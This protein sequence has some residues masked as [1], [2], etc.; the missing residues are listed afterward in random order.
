MKKFNVAL[1]QLAPTSSI[2]QNLAKGLD[3]CKKA[4]SLGADLALFPEMWQLNYNSDLM[5]LD[6]TIDHS[7]NFVQS[8]C[9]QA[10]QLNMA[11]AITY[12]GKGKNK[13]TNNV[14]VIDR[15]GTVVLDYAKVHVCDFAG[16]SEVALESGSEF[17]IAALNFAGGNVKL[18]AMIC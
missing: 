13:P 11:I 7:D 17:K 8:F 3:A 15:S 5:T 9:K 2:E 1:L 18:G 16:G 14:A 6:N 10:K 12:L 4:Q